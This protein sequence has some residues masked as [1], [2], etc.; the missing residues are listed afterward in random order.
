M[1]YR[2]T[3]SPR[4]TG[5]SGFD[6]LRSG[7]DT[8]WKAA[9]LK[10]LFEPLPLQQ[11]FIGEEKGMMSGGQM[12]PHEELTERGDKSVL[13]SVDAEG[14]RR[15]VAGVPVCRTP[16]RQMFGEPRAGSKRASRSF[17]FTNSGTMLPKFGEYKPQ[18]SQPKD[19]SIRERDAVYGG[20]QRKD[21]E[22]SV[23]I[24]LRSSPEIRSI[25]SQV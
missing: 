7:R 15:V 3:P 14:N 5:T 4:G 25:S 22:D 6:P 1:R 17:S 2:G 10:D 16:E 23:N 21:L 9:Q 19:S 11:M 13:K 18:M 20:N 8:P 12:L 24:I